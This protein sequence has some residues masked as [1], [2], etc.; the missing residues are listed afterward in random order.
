MLEP[1]NAHGHVSVSSAARILIAAAAFA[2]VSGIAFAAWLD[3]GAAI[4]LS[5][6]ETGLSWCF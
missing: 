2:A 5:M 1:M 3:H 6:A 4:F